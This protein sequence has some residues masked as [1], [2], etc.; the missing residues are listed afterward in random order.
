MEPKFGWFQNDMPNPFH[1]SDGDGIHNA[2]DD[3]PVSSS[4]SFS[5]GVTSGQILSVD[6]G[7]TVQIMDDPDLSKGVRVIVSGDAGGLATIRLDGSQ[8]AEELYRGEYIFTQGSVRL[9]V[10]DGK[11]QV[12][13]TINGVL[14]V[15]SVKGTVLLEEVIVDGVLQGVVV[16]AEEGIVTVNEK[17]VDPGE[18]H[19][20]KS[21]LIDIKPGS[22]P[23]CF[24]NDG[25]GV[26]PVAILSSPDFDATQVVPTTVS[27]NGQVIR[28]VGKGNTLSHIEDANGDGLD[29]LVVQIEDEDGIYQEGDTAATLTGETVGGT[30]IVG[31]D[32][33][34]IVP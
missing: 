24:N 13:F 14:S 10:L 8:L 16:N 3:D 9:K 20:V 21:V 25:N 5:D 31:T 6:A 34:C 1:D 19:T 30:S 23:N 15:V 11:A 28:V 4:A 32:T 26:I 12:K 22:T 2:V 17:V 18:S 29:D 7:M 27:L 33:I